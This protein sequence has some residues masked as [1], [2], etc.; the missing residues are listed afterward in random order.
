MIHKIV[1]INGVGKFVYYFS[2]ESNYNF[3]KNNAIYAETVAERIS[4][5]LSSRVR[6]S[7]TLK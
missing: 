7:D 2:S 4:Q 6:V 1:S 5:M 3:D